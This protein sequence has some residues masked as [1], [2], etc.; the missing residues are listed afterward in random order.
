[1]ST[2]LIVGLIVIFMVIISFNSFKKS[3]GEQTNCSNVHEYLAIPAVFI[4]I[5]IIVILMLP[6]VIKSLFSGETNGKK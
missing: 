1:M 2:Y 4:I 6:D 3:F 5:L